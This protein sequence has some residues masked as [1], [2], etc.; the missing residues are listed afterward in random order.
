MKLKKR[1]R[2]VPGRACCHFVIAAK[3]GCV[4]GMKGARIGYRNGLVTKKEF[5]ETLSSSQQSLDEIKFN[6]GFNRAIKCSFDFL[7]DL[8]L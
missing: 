8:S 6:Y 5:E 3:D 2:V 1:V 4:D 7:D